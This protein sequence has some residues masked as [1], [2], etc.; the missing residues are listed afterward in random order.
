VPQ[1]PTAE[2]V[3]EFYGALAA[4]DADAIAAV[5]DSHFDED[6]A[7][8]W[9]PSLPHGGRVHGRDRLRGVFTG[10][11]KAGGK[12]GATNLQL[13]Q[14]IGEG[15]RVVAWVTF[16][17]RQPG[18]DDAVPNSALELWTFSCG[19]VREIRAFYWDTAAIAEPQHA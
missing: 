10:I 17:W 16:D 4:A 8:K 9:P 5:I 15:D 2:I 13:V 12:V 14:T 18:S 7:V 11:A 3:A 1:H 6:A 19:L